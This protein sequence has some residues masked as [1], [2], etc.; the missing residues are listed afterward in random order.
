MCPKT[1]DHNKVTDHT[2]TILKSGHYSY[3]KMLDR[4]VNLGGGKGLFQENPSS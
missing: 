1:S 3:L 4:R 2:F